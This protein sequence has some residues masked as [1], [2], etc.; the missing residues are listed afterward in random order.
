MFA[1]KCPQLLGKNTSAGINKIVKSEHGSPLKQLSMIV[2]INKIRSKQECL[3]YTCIKCTAMTIFI[4]K[5]G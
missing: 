2:R 3:S 1:N 5:G 4:D